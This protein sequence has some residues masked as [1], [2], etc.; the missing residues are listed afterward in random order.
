MTQ[1][2]TEEGRERKKLNDRRENYGVVGGQ[3]KRES[4]CL[5]F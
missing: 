2:D 5:S 4:G 3:R 1:Q